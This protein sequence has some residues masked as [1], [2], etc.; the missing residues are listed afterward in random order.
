MAV[1]EDGVMSSEELEILPGVPSEERL[2]H[3]PVVVIECAQEIPCNPCELACRH[4]AIHI[5]ESITSL[6]QLDEELCTGCGLCI[7]ACPGQAIFVVDMTYSENEATVQ[8][9]YEMSPLPERGERVD[10]LNRAGKPICEG[11]VVRVVN[12]KSYDRTAV[13]T[14][15]VPKPCAMEVRNIAL[16]RSDDDAQ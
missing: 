6:P 1:L 12:P 11:S 2:A 5:G 9:P 4:G 13:V 16:R 14:V 10:A 7:A 15:G 3:G 8:L